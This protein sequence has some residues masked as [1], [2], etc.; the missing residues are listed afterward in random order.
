MTRL[1][2]GC[3][4][5]TRLPRNVSG[6]TAANLYHRRWSIEGA[7]GELTLSLN[8]E[9]ETLCYPQAALL[10]YAVALLTYNLLSVVN[11]AMSV[12][13]GTE[14]VDQRVSASPRPAPPA[15]KRACKKRRRGIVE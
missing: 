11:A 7:F 6:P 14:A 9:I 3:L 15:N 1:R 10:A 2:S 5:L 4:L 13:H 8:G 12:V